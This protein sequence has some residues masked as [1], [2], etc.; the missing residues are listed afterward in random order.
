M[1]VIPR[2]AS[3]LQKAM[4]DKDIQP[5]SVDSHL[6]RWLNMSTLSKG[7]SWC[8]GCQSKSLQPAPWDALRY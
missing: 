6:T 4:G 5:R 1:A 7:C 2:P 3:E 8:T